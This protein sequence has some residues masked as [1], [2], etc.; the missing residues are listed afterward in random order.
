MRKK[1]SVFGKLSER[2]ESLLGAL[3]FL[4]KLNLFAIP[5]YAIV[6]FN[7]QSARLTE[8]TADIVQ[9]LLAASGVQFE[10]AGMMF[11][12][13]V[14][15]GSW[16]AVINWDCVGWKSMLAMFA[17]VMATDC[18]AGKKLRGLAILVP[19]MYAANLLRIMFVIWLVSAYGVSYFAAVHDALWSWGLISVI[20][21]SWALWMRHSQ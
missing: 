11:S 4:L 1:R 6:L 15:G 19:A 3:K 18:P 13:P 2:N 12:V 16:A 14:A 10:R 8:I 17:L 21:A 7:I 5:L 20:L 9:F